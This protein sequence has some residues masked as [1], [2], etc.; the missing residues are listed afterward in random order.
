MEQTVKSEAPEPQLEI[1]DV[2]G[3]R[4]LIEAALYTAGR[5]LAVKT[6][7]HI[8]GETST[9]KTRTVARMLMEEYNLRRGALEI[10]ELEDDRFVMQLKPKYV[11]NVRRLS[12][13][14]LLTEGPLKTLSYIAY[15]QPVF[16]AKVIQARGAQAYLHIGELRK[17][18]LITKEKAGKTET[19]RTTD[20]FADYFNLSRDPRLMKPQL[21]KIFGRLEEAQK[22]RPA[23]TPPAEGVGEPSEAPHPVE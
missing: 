10:L 17:V 16:Q 1:E 9:K 18:G 15:R 19:L 11:H 23:P 6:L 7:S 2:E 21:E 20:L 22:K 4:R 8:A 13:K 5:P 12:F 3:K 14:P